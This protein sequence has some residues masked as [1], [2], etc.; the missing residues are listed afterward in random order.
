MGA[1]ESVRSR[2][3]R[4]RREVDEH[5]YRYYVLDEPSVDDAVYDALLRELTELEADHPELVTPESPTQRVGA[6][7]SAAFASVAHEAPMLSLANAFNEQEVADFDRRVR[8][9]LGLTE[10]DDP[11]VYTA[12]PKLDGLAVSL[13]Y[14]QGRFVRAATRGDGTTGEDVT[15]NIRTLRSVPLKLRGK[16]YPARF[17]VRGEVYMPKEGFAALNRRIEDDG[18]RPFVNPRNAAAG[19]LR[20]LD[21]S[22]TASRPLSMF[23]FAVGAVQ[24]DVPGGQFQL[25]DALKRWGLRVCPEA[26]QVRGAGGCIE[27]HREMA[28]RREALAYD[29][30]GVVY[31]VNSR[32]ARETL[33]NVS[34]APRWA[35]AHK[36]AAQELPTIVENVEFQV[37]RTG[38][39]TPVA[40]LKPVFV[41]GVTVS[42]ATLHNMDELRR[43]DVRVG[44]TVIVRR[45][46]DVIPE[47]VSVVMSKRPA[48]AREVE[49][50]ARCPVCDSGVVRPEGQAVY[51]CSGGLYCPAQRVRAIQH[52]V[53]R[54]AL[55]IEGLGD[56]LVAQLVENG[57]VYSPADI[58]DLTA[59]QLIALDRMGEKS[60]ASLLSAIEGSKHPS[61][62]RFLHAL[63]IREV[64]ESTASALASHFGTLEALMESDAESLQQTPDVGPVVA[65]Y[66]VQFFAEDRNREII[67]RLLAS[68][69]V[70]GTVEKTAPPADGDKGASAP[71]TGQTFV[72]TGTLE[73]LTREEAR[74]LIEQR[75]GKVSGS[76][77]RKT[78]YLVAGESPGSK[79]DKAT[80]LGVE[81]LDEAAFGALLER[82]EKEP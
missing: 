81:V 82:T 57:L 32:E 69:V 1:G 3:E 33:G 55:D 40:R 37:G 72:L 2:L 25:L 53:S 16:G 59:E 7:P 19:S 70:P 73:H 65:E 13:L 4:L 56:K 17:E 26:R 31:K 52:F 47:V 21:A 67:S 24:G 43:K 78:A 79:L 15:H 34:R 12:E 6:Q 80:T 10:D 39:L 5:N 35:V 9:R 18:G 50:P 58:Y 46:G 68:G 30:D 45:A 8:E 27:F 76:V 74:S 77:S 44:D 29:I 54:R 14:E 51:R 75:G 41:G 60:A 28:E 63:G 62:A 42:N 64:G 38:A 20:Q 66:V 11:V 71:L 49:V 36:F 22:I 61:L 23:C 48:S